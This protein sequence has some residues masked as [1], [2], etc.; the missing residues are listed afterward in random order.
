MRKFARFVVVLP[1]GHDL[2]LADAAAEALDFELHFR[3]TEV[4]EGFHAGAL[5]G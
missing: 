4:G 5:L 3:E 1:D 2:L